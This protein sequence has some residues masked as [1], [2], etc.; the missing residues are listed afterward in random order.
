[1]ESRPPGIFK[2]FAARMANKLAAKNLINPQ[3]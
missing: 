1:M 3:D 2:K